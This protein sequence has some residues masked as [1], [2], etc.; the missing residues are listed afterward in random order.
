M[1]F[2]ILKGWRNYRIFYFPLDSN[3]PSLSA[4]RFLSTD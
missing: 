1:A 3:T 4:I 2:Y